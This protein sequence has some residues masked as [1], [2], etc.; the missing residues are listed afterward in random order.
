MTDLDPGRFIAAQDGVYDRVLRELEEGAKRTH[1]MWFIFPQIAG[2]GLSATAQHYA[3]PSRAAARAYAAHPVLG[4]RLRACTALVNA[5]EGRSAH[6]IFA[7]PDD[8][9]FRSCMTLFA[10]DGEA[11]FLEALAKYFGGEPDRRT[12]EILESTQ[13][14][15]PSKVGPRE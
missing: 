12:L 11:V 2:L 7:T 13:S 6:D 15:S 1:W 14:P 5:V 4:D 8:M 3:I 9:K 10:Q